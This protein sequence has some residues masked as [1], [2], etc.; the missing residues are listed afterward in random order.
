MNKKHMSYLQFKSTADK[1]SHA[2]DAVT[3][4][5]LYHMLREISTEEEVREYFKRWSNE[6]NIDGQPIKSEQSRT[7]ELEK[8]LSITRATLE[9]TADAILIID[10]N[11][12]LTDFNQKFLEVTE[13]PPAIIESGEENAGLGYLLGLLED[14]KELIEQMQYLM[15]HPDKDGDMGDVHFKN[16]KI[17]ERYSQPHRI[18]NEIV[19]RVWSF[20]DVTE[21]R[22]Q[23]ESLRLTNRAIT[24]ST[25]GI[26]LIENNPQYPITYMN[27]A[28][29]HLFNMEESDAVQKPFLTAV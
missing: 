5:N 28:G 7:E 3:P 12:K 13:V 26:I 8:S 16:G 27:P 11:G 17:V 9:S 21:K 10:K 19:G 14:P 29:L 23:E 6:K 4:E 1:L 25:H 2:H 22:K 20:R 18:G 15:M 24:A